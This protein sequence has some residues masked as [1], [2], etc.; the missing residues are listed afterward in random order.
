MSAGLFAPARVRATTSLCEDVRLIELEPAGGAEPYDPGSHLDVG[1]ELDGLP[2][3]RSYSLIGAGPR[4]GAYRIAVK[5]VADSRGGSAAMHALRVDDTVRITR[6]RS[7][8][9][10]VH[11][12]PEYLLV[13]GGIGIT[14]LYAMAEAL[15]RAGASFRLLYAA[16]TRRQLV[17]AEELGAL[18]GERLQC[19]ASD[20]G[21]RIDLDR[22]VASLHP[23]GELY[24]CGPLRLR[25]A[26]QRVWAASDRLPERLRFE[27]FATG[28][29]FPTESFT[30][31]LC[32]HGGR[33]LVVPRERTLLATLRA[34]GVELMADCLRG[35]CGL[36]QVNVVRCDAA[37]DHR[38]VFLSDEERAE[39]TTLCACV[40]RAAGGMV[41]IDTGF[42]PAPTIT[43]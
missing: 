11:G 41:E 25:E 5:R 8:F 33:E 28:G 30:V 2:D 3:L 35:E 13:A 22:H 4:N 12:R 19:F 36:C 10:L 6:P 14:P 21:E 26:V 7:N 39:A 24:L 20:R 17:L 1:L 43:R 31:R 29:R 18:V 40:S 32:D 27:T 42:R 23:E 37:L 15:L 34:S 38:D 9:P 16:A